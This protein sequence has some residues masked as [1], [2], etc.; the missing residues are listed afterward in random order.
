MK[1]FQFRQ[2]EPNKFF[3]K[4]RKMPKKIFG[5]IAFFDHSVLKLNS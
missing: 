2:I 4:I 5:K 3:L 1:K